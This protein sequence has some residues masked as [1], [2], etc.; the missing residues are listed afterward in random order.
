[1]Y[2][3]I[4]YSEPASILM[5]ILLVSPTVDPSPIP[6]QSPIILVNDFSSVLSTCVFYDVTWSYG[7]PPIGLTLVA[8]N[9]GVPQNPPPSSSSVRPTPTFS[10]GGL[11]LA[12]P[13]GVSQ[14]G[15]VTSTIVQDFEPHASSIPWKVNVPPGWYQISA[16]MESQFQDQSD[17][18]YVQAGTDTSCLIGGPLPST[19]SSTS[20]SSS[21]LVPPTATSPAPGQTAIPVPSSA[22]KDTRVGIIVGVVA[23]A[24]VFMILVL[25]AYLCLRRRK[26]ALDRPISGQSGGAQ[27][28]RGWGGLGSLSSF[29]SNRFNKRSHASRDLTN[30]TR[31]SGHQSATLGGIYAGDGVRRSGNFTPFSPSEEKFSTSPV[32]YAKDP[33]DDSEG[34]LALATLPSNGGRPTASSRSSLQQSQLSPPYLNTPS[35][36]T[37]ASEPPLHQPRTPSIDASSYFPAPSSSQPHSHSSSSPLA[38]ADMARSYSAS[39]SGGAASSSNSHQQQKKVNRQSIGSQSITA[40]KTPRKPVPA[41]DPSVPST[42]APTPT[43]GSSSPSTAFTPSP[44]TPTNPSPLALAGQSHYSKKSQHSTSTPEVGVLTHKSSFGPGGVEGKPV[45]YLMPDMPLPRKD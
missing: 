29:Q 25:M 12:V 2:V 37:F 33:F 41:Y 44:A 4:H 11:V 27:L 43:P 17:P 45:H 3:A 42:D 23:G 6:T 18:F 38:T 7:G 19:S 31:E 20:A 40:R 5:P 34:G 14:A 30:A 8:T 35:V 10:D 9:F 28:R 15:T 16:T 32:P 36:D 26:T 21:T 24:V 1:M 39:S 22:S 13:S